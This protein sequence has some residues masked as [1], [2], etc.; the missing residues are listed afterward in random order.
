MSRTINDLRDHLFDTIAAVRDGR[1][2]IEQARTIG[3]LSQVIVNTAKVEI[4]FARAADR[5]AVEFLGHEVIPMTRID[6]ASRQPA[7][8]I[9][10][11]TQ[12]VLGE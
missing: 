12:H 5:K 10:S 8:G 1:M 7:N 4:D 6:A 11:I 2:S 3:D 9:M